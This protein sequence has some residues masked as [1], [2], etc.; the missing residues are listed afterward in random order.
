MLQAFALLLLCQLAGDAFARV[1]GLPLPGAVVG[2][3]LLLAGLLALGRV[4]QGL[5]R[6][7]DG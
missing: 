2:L 4:P 6:C 3:V 7:A 5:G 1:S